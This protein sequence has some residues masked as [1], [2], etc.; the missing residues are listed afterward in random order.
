[1][2]QLL[3]IASVVY[4]SM[5]ARTTSANNLVINNPSLQ[6]QNKIQHYVLIKFDVSCKY[7]I[8]RTGLN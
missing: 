8:F 1:M 2:R 6:G 7:P 5:F 3:K 4:Y